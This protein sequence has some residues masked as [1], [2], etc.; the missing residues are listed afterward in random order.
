M[1]D[2]AEVCSGPEAAVASFVFNGSFV[3][4]SGRPFVID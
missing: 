1:D 2:D 3:P 4:H